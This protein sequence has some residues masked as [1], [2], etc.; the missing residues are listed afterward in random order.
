[1]KRTAVTV[2]ILLAAISAAEARRMS[3]PT[4]MNDPLGVSI[5]PTMKPG[6]GDLIDDTPTS[7]IHEIHAPTG[8]TP[9]TVPSDPTGSSLEPTL[10]VSPQAPATALP[11]TPAN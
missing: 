2:L 5:S 10:P 4:V 8:M 11:L 7:T 6:T 9:L 3:P 1:M